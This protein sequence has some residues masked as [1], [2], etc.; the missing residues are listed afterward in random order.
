MKK[1]CANG[2]CKASFEVTDDDLQ[3]YERVSPVFA[4]KKYPLPPPVNCPDCRQRHR[5]ALCNE[6]F[7]YP[8]TCALCKKRT[9]TQYPPWQKRTVYCR[10]C[11]HGDGWDPCDYGRDIDFSRPFF[12][13]MKELQ[14][15]VPVENLLT[16]G[17]VENAEYIHYAG[18]A[19]NCYLI[20]H[21]DF[22]EDCYYGYGFKH[23]RSCVDGFYNLQSELLYDCIDC[24]SCYGLKGCQDCNN[25]QSS[26]FL[27]D[28]VGCKDC[29]LCVGLRGKEFCFENQQLSK[30]GY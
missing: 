27:R 30:K 1:T 2:W 20:Q 11:W 28:C 17:T 4:G 21:A 25:C 5:L 14:T 22:C 23:V 24:L 7:F 10:E 26:M 6:Q 13:Q 29:F 15:I 9:I 19:K 8:A 3:F 18:F 12:D 16:A